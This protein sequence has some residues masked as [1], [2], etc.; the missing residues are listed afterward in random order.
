MSLIFADRVKETTTTTGTGVLTLAGAVDG[1]QSFDDAMADDDTCYYSIT[2][3]TDWETGLGTYSA[4]TLT[5]TTV[6]ESTNSNAAVDWSAGS[7]DI[8]ITIPS[9]IMPD[10]MRNR[11]RW[12]S[13]MR[14]YCYTDTRWISL[15]D[16]NYGQNTEN[17]SE[18]AGTGADPIY[19]WEVQGLPFRKGDKINFMDIRA[20]TNSTEITDMEIYMVYLTPNPITRWETGFDNDSED[21]FEVVYRDF[22]K[23]PTGGEE[24]ETLSGALNDRMKRKIDLDYTCPEDGEFRIFFKPVGTL[25]ATRY[26]YPT[27]GID[28]DIA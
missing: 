11:S 1:F 18:S 10:I 4:D 17:A 5:R 27:I 8:F 12:I 25:T 22:W 15:S 19:E 28:Y 2:D 14:V 24:N 20:R 26:F 23:N 16:D 9:S 6:L 21:S 13:T 3:G 7:K